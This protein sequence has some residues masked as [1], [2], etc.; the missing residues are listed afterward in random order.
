MMLGTILHVLFQTAVSNRKYE[1]SELNKL[2]IDL[3]KKRQIVS[4][5]YGVGLDEESVIKETAVYLDSIEKWLRDHMAV[6][7]PNNGKNFQ[8]QDICDIEE[9]IWSPKYGVKGKLDLTLRISLK[10]SAFKT[11]NTNTKENSFTNGF[12]HHVIPAEL[13]S[14]KTTFSAEHEGQLMLYSMLNH[15]KRNSTDFGLLLY[16]K[17]MNM[18]FIKVNRVSLRGK[19]ILQGGYIST[20]LTI[21][22]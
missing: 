17:D 14:G 1:K 19:H 12:S 16:L 21:S 22:Y 9:S 5:L 2:L 6:K 10:M 8:I 15:E 3:L 7:Q 11:L 20:N 18:K 4:Q 13:K